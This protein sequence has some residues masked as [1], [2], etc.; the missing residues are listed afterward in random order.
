VKYRR[1]IQKIH[2]RGELPLECILIGHIPYP[3]FESVRYGEIQR[4]TADT[5]RYSYIRTDIA[6]YSG[7]QRDIVDPLQNG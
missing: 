7:I 1:G 4:E 6:R 5:A 2:A 3:V